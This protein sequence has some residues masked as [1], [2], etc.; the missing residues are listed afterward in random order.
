MACRCSRH[1]IEL[2]LQLSFTMSL[3]RAQA[4]SLLIGEDDEEVGDVEGGE[5]EALVVLA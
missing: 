4:A 3:G 1:P 5:V 2:E